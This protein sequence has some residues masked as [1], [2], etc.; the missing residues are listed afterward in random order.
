MRWLASVVAA[1]LAYGDP[2]LCLT[3]ESRVGARL[4]GCDAIRALQSWK[5]TSG[6]LRR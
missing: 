1:A 4:E 6:R 2:R 3:A 5:G